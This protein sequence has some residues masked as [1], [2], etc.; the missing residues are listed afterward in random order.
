MEKNEKGTPNSFKNK[1]TSSQ[2][3]VRLGDLDVLQTSTTYIKYVEEGDINLLPLLLLPLVLTPPPTMR[4]EVG[5]LFCL[6]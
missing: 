1:I 5:Q 6:Y 4:S 3:T 2:I